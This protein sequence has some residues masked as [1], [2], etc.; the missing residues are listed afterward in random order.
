MR[1]PKGQLELTWMGKDM[2]LIPAEDGKYDYEWVDPSDPRACEV[3]TIEVV[4]T[5]GET[6]GATGANEN[7]LIVGDSG[8]A[9]RSIGT[10]PEWASRYK[11]KVKLVYIDPPFNTEQTFE[12]YVD[13][14]EHSIWLTMMRDRIRDI[15]P[16]LAED[17]SIWIHLDD[18]EVH[19]MRVV[20]DEEFGPENFIAAVVW[21]ASDNSNNDAN[22]FSEDH[23]T[24]LG[25]AKAPGWRSNRLPANGDKVSH[26]ANPDNDPDGAWFDGNP[27]NSPNPRE[28][29][30]YTISSPTGYE[31]QPPPNGWRWS[32][33]TLR[34]KIGSGE[35]RFTPDGKGIRRRTY[36]KDH[37]GLPPS[38]LWT[39][40]EETGH[41]RQAKS[42]LKALFPGRPTADL[43]ATPKP[44]RLMHRLLTLATLEGDLVLD[45]FAGSGTTAA[46]AHKLGR[47]WVTVELL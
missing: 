11:G 4:K 24:I 33:E 47:R 41:T 16:L 21:R 32:V 7:L 42:E 40:L 45:C 37:A 6:A 34:E 8:D 13:Q 31:I 36:L 5:V 20:L 3:K 2:A 12:H 1:S 27:L 9:L 38:T 28:N 15:K 25:Y 39:N 46:V 29:L 43:F 18:A 19:R 35:I 44:E 22:Q 30:R 10:V 26:Y 14:L 17:A 23:N